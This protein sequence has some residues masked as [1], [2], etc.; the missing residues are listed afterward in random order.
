MIQIDGQ[1]YY[2]DL[3][4]I[5]KFVFGEPAQGVSTEETKITKAIG[6]GELLIEKTTNTIDYNEKTIQIRYDLIKAMLD[7]TYNSGVESQNGDIAYIQD[8]ETNSIGSKLI[9]NTLLV[10]EFIKNKAE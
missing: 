10:N 5:E 3:K 1:F 6:E 8:M 7:S 4:E 2:I 9:F